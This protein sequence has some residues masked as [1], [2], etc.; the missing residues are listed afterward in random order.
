MKNTPIHQFEVNNRIQEYNAVFDKKLGAYLEARSK[1]KKEAVID[2]MFEY[3]FFKPSKLKKWSPGFG[4][5]LHID[6]SYKELNLEHLPLIQFDSYS[7]LD[8][9][10][11]PKKRVGALIWQLNLQEAILNQTKQ[12]NCFGLH[13]WAMLYK[14]DEYRHPYLSLR[15][16]QEVIDETVQNSNLK[17]THFDAY[18]FFT[19]EAL[20]LNQNQLDRDKVLAF[21]QGGC[22][23]NNMDLYKWVTK[24]YPFTSTELIWDCFCFALDTRILD[25]EASPYDVQDYGYGFVPIET[26]AGRM[27][28][29]TRQKKLAERA[30]NLRIR[31]IKELKVIKDAFD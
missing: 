22:L 1:G 28:Y 23:H 3:Y 9:K 20:P 31:L 18:R 30:E 7:T 24:F 25:M 6:E 17:C 16:S 11:F 19:Q 12:F 13:E 29:A 8:I 5:I 15:I 2:F 26:H 4:K 27:E 10:A 14:T 21:E